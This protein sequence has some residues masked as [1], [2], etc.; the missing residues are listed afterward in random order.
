MPGT[1]ITLELSRTGD[2]SPH[3]QQ[4]RSFGA[5]ITQPPVTVL[6]LFPLHWYPPWLAG[7]ASMPASL[8]SKSSTAHHRLSDSPPPL[9]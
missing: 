3:T 2:R 5:V 9:Q 1:S 7:A 6:S 4:A 8:S